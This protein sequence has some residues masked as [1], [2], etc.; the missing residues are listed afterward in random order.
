MR[1][2]LPKPPEQRRR[3]NASSIESSV[4][5]ASGR[6]GNPPRPPKSVNLG[7]AGKAWWRWAWK[8]PQA[9]KWEYGMVPLVARRASLEDDLV[10]AGEVEGL[11]MDDLL[12]AA[13]AKDRRILDNLIRGL[14]RLATGRVAIMKE[15]RELDDR[16]GLS[17]K[18]FAGLRWSIGEDAEEAET[19]EA[20]EVVKP[21][22]WGNLKVA[23]GA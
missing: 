20:G 10:T 19:D 18:A 7:S 15:M 16:L 1:G 23:D 22:R 4:L 21:E 17:P 12:A 2:P 3:R 5:P 6:P 14:A 9:V 11:D 8:T 13:D